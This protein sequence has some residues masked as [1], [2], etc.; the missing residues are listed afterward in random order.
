MKKLKEQKSKCDHSND[1]GIGMCT[2]CGHQP[3]YCKDVT[4]K[5]CLEYRL[6]VLEENNRCKYC[7][8]KL[9]SISFPLY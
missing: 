8:G 3:Q 5:Q 9:I 1:V 2:A 7:T 4:H 6:R